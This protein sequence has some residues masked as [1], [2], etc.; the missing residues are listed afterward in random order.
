M[1]VPNPSNRVWFYFSVQGGVKGQK[2]VLNINNFTKKRALYRQG[3]TPVVKSSNKE[4]SR[5]PSA[6]VFYYKSARN[7]KRYVL[8]II[9]EFDSDDETYY[10]AYSYPYTYSKLQEYLC[11]LSLKSYPFFKREFLG[12]S[13]ENRRLDLLTITAEGDHSERKTVCLTARVHPGESPASWVC[14]G[15]IDFLTSDHS[16]ARALRQHLIFKIVPMLNPD[17]VFHGNYRASSLGF[18]L[19]RYWKCP[20]L[21]YHPEIFYVKELFTRMQR[22]EDLSIALYLDIHAHSCRSNTFIC[23]LRL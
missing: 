1:H 12:Y 5:L 18:D 15:I 3:A 21:K 11:D 23:K 2:V 10:F 14:Q 16:S 6:N 19:N 20:S 4:W 13:V 7:Y 9:F 8:S 17:G 22:K